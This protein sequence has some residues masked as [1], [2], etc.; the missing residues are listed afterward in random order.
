MTH[1]ET[2][3]LLVRSADGT[4]ITASVGGQGP[5][6]VLVHG[7]TGSDFSWARV[8]PHLEA[9]YRVYAMQRRGRGRSGDGPG[10]ALVREAEDVSAV[11]DAL[12]EPAVLVGHSFGADCSLEA[13]LLTANLSGLV[14]YEPAFGWP[15]DETILGRVDALVEAGELEHATETYLREA[16]RLSDEEMDLLRAQPTWTERVAAAHTLGREDRAA[17]SYAF[18]PERFAQMEVPTLLLHGSESPPAFRE[19]IDALQAALPDS[20]VRIL[21]GQGHAANVTAPELLA[22]QILRFVER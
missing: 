10:Y 17:A 22:T 4:T 11:V 21:E 7:T 18:I 3:P 14:L 12:G 15:V 20:T 16:V 13:S 5:P 9:R 19:R 8:R 6:V 2:W 1:T